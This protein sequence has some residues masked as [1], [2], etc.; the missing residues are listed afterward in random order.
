MSEDSKNDDEESSG[1]Q[2]RTVLTTMAS[3]ASLAVGGSGLASAA[4]DPVKSAERRQIEAKFADLTAIQSA[5]ATHGSAL[6]SYIREEEGLEDVVEENIQDF[7][8]KRD[9]RVDA[10]L[11]NHSLTPQ[12]RITIEEEEASGHF[13]VQPSIGRSIFI[14][15]SEGVSK[16]IIENSDG[17]VGTESCYITDEC[18]D[19]ADCG[20]EAPYENTALEKECCA[21][22]CV[23]N[24]TGCCTGD[25]KGETC[26]T[27]CPF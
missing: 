3:G 23:W 13:Y 5:V 9:N 25:C 19:C 1:V 22:S 11:I 8:Q 27:C 15:D 18:C 26:D 10:F 12:I 21:G 2:R 24:K 4:T 7:I 14:Y 16:G 6:H 17:E 20:D